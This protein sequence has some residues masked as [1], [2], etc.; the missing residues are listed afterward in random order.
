MLA[1]PD[2]LHA[3]KYKLALD[4]QVVANQH[5]ITLHTWGLAVLFSA[6]YV[7][8]IQYPEAVSATLELLQR[9]V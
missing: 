2:L 6:Y 7:F 1:G 4:G 3:E 5:P 8:G 9:Y